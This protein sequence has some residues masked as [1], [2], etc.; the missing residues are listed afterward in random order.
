MRRFI[1]SAGGWP[2]AWA[3]HAVQSLTGPAARPLVPPA[4]A[5][6]CA[7]RPCSV[8]AAGTL[9]WCPPDGR[10]A[11]IAVM[12]AVAATSARGVA[13]WPARLPGV[14]PA[15]RLAARVLRAPPRGTRAAVG[16]GGA[17]GRR[18]A[19]AQARWGGQAVDAVAVPGCGRRRR[20]LRPRGGVAGGPAGG[21]RRRRRACGRD[22]FGVTSGPCGR[23]ARVGSG[24]AG[25]PGGLMNQRLCV[26]TMSCPAVVGRW[27]NSR[28]RGRGGRDRKRGVGGVAVD[29]DRRVTAASGRIHQHGV[30]RQ[31][32]GQRAA[33]ASTRGGRAGH[34]DG[35]DGRTRLWGC[36]PWG[37]RVRPPKRMR[38]GGR[39]PA[40]RT[41]RL[42]RQQHPPA[43]V[44]VAP[45]PGSPFV[46][47]RGSLECAA[48]SP[49][50]PFPGKRRT[51]D[52][53]G[54]DTARRDSKR[55]QTAADGRRRG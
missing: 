3:P 42:V 20:C 11:P 7:I 25:P 39:R 4:R 12:V 36:P 44:A 19:A 49:P 48:P 27:G 30:Q 45:Q 46:A 53:A 26:C 18:A 22:G 16:R 31:R 29:G 34:N 8:A 6:V 41:R 35:S 28:K 2:C 21:A 50:P 43:V 10:P 23:T 9:W 52:A 47:R 14:P 33:G 38:Q 54:A 51:T 37:Q 55:R 17:P 40:V 24:C 1:K 15:A 5:T 13:Q 32:A